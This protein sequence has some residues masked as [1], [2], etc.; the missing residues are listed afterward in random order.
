MI[1]VDGDAAPLYRGTVAR[2]EENGL[3][4]IASHYITL[5]PAAAQRDED[6]LGRHDRA[7]RHLSRGQS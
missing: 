2:I 1:D 5:Q 3:A 6:P 4:G 7:E